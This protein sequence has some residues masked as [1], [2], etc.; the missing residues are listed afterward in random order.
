MSLNESGVKPGDSFI[1][2]SISITHSIYNS[3]DEGHDA[4]DLFV[5]I[6]KAFD[7]VWHE[8]LLFKL[9]QN[10]ITGEILNVITDF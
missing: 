8:G 1:N 2:Q 6:W 9:K 5:D 10:G 7:K 3:F 4:R